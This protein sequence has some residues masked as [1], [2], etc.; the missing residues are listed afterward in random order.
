MVVVVVA[1]TAVAVVASVP[2]VMATAMAARAGLVKRPV[3]VK[4]LVH[5]THR[6]NVITR[7]GQR[8]RDLRQHAV[9]G[10]DVRRA[11]QRRQYQ[12][13]GRAALFELGVVVGAFRCG[14]AR[15]QGRSQQ[16]PFH[17]AESDD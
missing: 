15:G 2:V 8:Q 7:F 6:K 13:R 14:A 1:V 12:D 11:V 17:W 10:V 16:E 3:L 4:R 9:A 5:Q